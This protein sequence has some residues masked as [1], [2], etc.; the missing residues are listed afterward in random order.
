MLLAKFEVTAFL[1]LFLSF[2]FACSHVVYTSTFKDV[3][4]NTEHDSVVFIYS[5]TG[6]NLPHV[7]QMFEEISNLTSQKFPRVHFF[8]VETIESDLISLTDR[9][10][11]DINTGTEYNSLAWWHYAFD[12]SL[13]EL[14]GT[15]GTNNTNALLLEQIYDR[16]DISIMKRQTFDRFI[17]S[18]DVERWDNFFSQWNSVLWKDADICVKMTLDTDDMMK[19]NL[20]ISL[21]RR[22]VKNSNSKYLKGFKNSNLK[23]LKGFKKAM[24]SVFTDK[25]CGNSTE[26]LFVYGK[27]NVRIENVRRNCQEGNYINFV[28]APNNNNSNN[29]NTCSSNDTSISGVIIE[30]RD[31]QFLNYVVLNIINELPNVRPI[32]I[33]HGNNYQ[34]DDQ[35]KSMIENGSIILHQLAKN[36]L[37]ASSYSKLMTSLE[38]WFQFKTDKILVFQTDSIVCKNSNRYQLERFLSFDYIGAPLGH[39]Q[40]GNG[41]F[42]IRDRRLSE[43]CSTLGG[44]DIKWEDTYF[45]A[46]IR[47]HGGKMAGKKEQ[48]RFAT[49]QY[50][51]NRSFGAHQVNWG[52][53]KS[54]TDL[55]EFRKTCP[56]Y[57]T[58]MR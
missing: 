38:F 15:T 13:G 58:G 27:E 10:A 56:N 51:N 14:L 55:N 30:P 4:K 35:I 9:C 33:F 31:H 54:V 44:Y 32:H 8:A 37:T 3:I 16:A 5:K 45:A 17:E 49:Q 50:L 36:N 26:T 7:K 11:S 39:I 34:F 20:E 21:W 52:L 42:S 43:Q 24:R 41:G 46:C 12:K 25:S 2:E 53:R 48:E 40:H 23:Y 28:K 6:Q 1:L 47:L 57:L 22:M 29:N 19:E 18:S